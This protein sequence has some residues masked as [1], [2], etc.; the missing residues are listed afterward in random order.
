MGLTFTILALVPFTEIIVEN[1]A[2]IYLCDQQGGAHYLEKPKPEY[3]YSYQRRRDIKAG[4]ASICVELLLRNEYPFIELATDIIRPG[5]LPV[6]KGVYR[7]YLSGPYDENCS[8]YYEALNEVVLDFSNLLADSGNCLAAK[9][10]SKITAEIRFR[11]KK[12][13]LNLLVGSVFHRTQYLVQN[14]ETV[15]AKYE[16]FS[17]TSGFTNWFFPFLK[18]KGCGADFFGYSQF[19]P[20]TIW[21]Q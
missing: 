15:L 14:D 8:L 21:E 10:V 12:G 11:S 18:S 2:V 20:N 16:R 19:R 1:I 17:P 4:C 7:Y 9:K 6:E 3:G 5:V 13:Y